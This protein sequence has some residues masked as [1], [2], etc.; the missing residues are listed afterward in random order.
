MKAKIKYLWTALL[1]MAALT[2]LSTSTWGQSTSRKDLK[3][4]IGIWRA[5]MNGLPAVTLTI[6][7]EDGGLSGA[8]LF[9][10][11]RQ[12]KGSKAVSTSGA[13]QPLFDLQFDG[14]E[15]AFQVRHRGTQPDSFM[16]D[17]VSFR[18]KLTGTNAG[19]LIRGDDDSNPI[20]IVKNYE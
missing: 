8:A 12:D 4:I 13:P 9:Y 17:R 6:S 1:L 18:L 10:L 14:K 20:P 7:E 2:F 5:Q 19:Q 15:L 16:G 11:M 3:P